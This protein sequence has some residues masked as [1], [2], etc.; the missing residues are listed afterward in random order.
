MDRLL[1]AARASGSLNLSNRSLKE[2]PDQLYKSLDAVGEGEN[3][4][5]AVELQKLILAHN[6]IE[7]LKED[8]RNLPMLSVLNISHN[9]LSHLPAAIG[10]LKSL[11]ALDVSYNLLHEI[12]EEVGSAA[13][14][15]KF[16]CSSNQLK[17]LPC[18]LGNCLDLSDLKASNNC[19]TSLPED[20]G[21]CSKLSKLDVEGNKLTVLS[22]KSVASWTLL[23]ELNAGMSHAFSK[24]ALSDIPESVGN[25]SRLIRLDLHQNSEYQVPS[26]ISS[27]PSSIRGCSSLA[28]FYMGNNSLTSLPTVIGELTNLGT[29]DLHSNQLTEFPVEACKLRLSGLDLSN[30]SLSGLPP[31]IGKSPVHKIEGEYS[32]FLHQMRIECLMTTLR[33]LV[34]TGNPIRTLRSSLVSG[35]TPALLKFLRSRLPAEEEGGTSGNKKEVIAMASRLSLG[36]K[37]LSLGGHG[38]NVVPPQVW[39]TSGITKVDLSKNSIEVL[40]VELSSCASLETLILSRNKIK[41]WPSAILESLCN[42]VCLKL[43]S[44]PLRQIPLDGFQA[45]SKLQVLDLSGNAGCLPEYPAFSFLLQVQE[46]YLRRM[47]ISEIRGDILSLP[48]LRVLDMSQNSLQ[49]IPEGFKDATSLQELRLS[50]NNI[51]ALPPELGLL[52]PTLNVLQLDGNP[53]RSYIEVP[54]G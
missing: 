47:Q 54:E 4:W 17:N 37:E 24:N 2:V 15:I 22:E 7:L 46:L 29:F 10:E 12:P 31:E 36:S 53:L 52:E 13:S 28:E 3:W 23:M 32:L 44:N 33:K 18:S 14:L 8:I 48:K 30:N 41:E 11:K 45:A 51:S 16:D 5:E 19:L 35:P 26:R 38:L 6:D 27:I 49:L 43:D 25:L 9:K 1:K 34:L 50:D 42:L 40:P 21:N 39:E 20:L